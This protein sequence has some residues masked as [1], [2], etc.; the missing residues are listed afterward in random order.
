MYQTSQTTLSDRSKN[1]HTIHRFTINRVLWHFYSYAYIYVILSIFITFL[2]ISPE[3]LK[4]LNRLRS[5]FLTILKRFKSVQCLTPV[6]TDRH[7]YIK[8]NF[9]NFYYHLL[10]LNL[11]NLWGAKSYSEEVVSTKLLVIVPRI[12]P[13]NNYNNK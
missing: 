4:P 6:E 2:S 3:P 9:S 8:N 1:W 10:Y 5:K 13:K 7:I 12:S 11:G